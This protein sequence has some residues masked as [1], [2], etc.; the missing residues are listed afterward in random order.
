[1]TFRS[2]SSGNDEVAIV[3]DDSCAWVFCVA[4]GTSQGA[5]DAEEM[6]IASEVDCSEGDFPELPEDE[7]CMS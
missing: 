6:S 2:E 7:D 3:L 5:F 4:V 1:M